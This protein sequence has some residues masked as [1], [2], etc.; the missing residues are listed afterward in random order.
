MTLP[1]YA[2]KTTSSSLR[3]KYEDRVA[4]YGPA[5]KG[6]RWHKVGDT[7]TDKT[8]FANK[9]DNSWKIAACVGDKIANSHFAACYPIPAKKAPTVKSGF[10]KYNGP[11]LSSSHSYNEAVRIAGPAPKGYKYLNV[12]DTITKDTIAL[13]VD[14]WIKAAG[15][16][17]TILSSFCCPRAVPTK[18]TPVSLLDAKIASLEG[19]ITKLEEKAK[20]VETEQYR[21]SRDLN[22]RRVE[23]KTLRAAAEILNKKA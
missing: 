23:L 18:K 8:I 6:Y 20:A 22:E 16:G 12:G 2:P 19:Q 14:Q 3:D 17:D 15:V 11:K 7:Q 13:K 4:D 10:P 9:F 21:L 5:P 1:A